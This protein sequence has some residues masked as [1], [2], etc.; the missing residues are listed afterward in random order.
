[1]SEQTLP[2]SKSAGSKAPA[3]LESDEAQMKRAITKW[4]GFNQDVFKYIQHLGGHIRLYNRWGGAMRV[5]IIIFSATITTLSDIDSVPRTLITVIAGILTIITGVEAYYKFTERSFDAKKTQRE[6]EELRDK[7]RY[8]WFVDVEIG[9]GKL[10]ERL[11]SARRMLT[12]GPAE[13]NGVLTKYVME[14]EKAEAPA[15]SEG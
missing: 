15:I 8:A 11:E 10:D 12:D 13:Y 4:V 9:S 2:E 14:S 1:M 3:L 6:L 5:V 7:L